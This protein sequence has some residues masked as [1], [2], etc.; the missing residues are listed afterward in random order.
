MHISRSG[1]AAAALAG[2]FL[3]GAWGGTARGDDAQPKVQRPILKP[4]GLPSTVLQVSFKMGD[5]GPKWSSALDIDGKEMLEFQWKTAEAGAAKG[6]WDIVDKDGKVVQTGKLDKAPPSGQYRL[7]F[8]DFATVPL[9]DQ[10]RVRVQPLSASDTE[11]GLPSPPVTIKKAGP[12]API[13]FTDRGL[14]VPI[15]PMLEQVR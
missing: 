7:F 9:K 4:I 14:D 11:T 10:V 3:A 13:H 1:A 15:T 8:I 5:L 6:R 12:Q 2:L